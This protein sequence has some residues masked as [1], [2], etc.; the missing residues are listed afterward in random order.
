MGAAIANM[1]V[2]MLWYGPVFGKTWRKLMGFSETDM[3]KM[4][5]TAGQAIAGGTITALLMSY[6]L[7][8]EAFVWGS[9]MGESGTVFFAFMLAFWPWLGFVAT[10]QA[11]SF[12]WE[13]KSFKLFAFNAAA[14][15]VSMF[16]MALVLTFI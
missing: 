5:L 12:L 8:H 13:G 16:A 15:M 4:P 1:I 11:G 10:T 14:S 2:G 9:F 7:A 3:K 6:I